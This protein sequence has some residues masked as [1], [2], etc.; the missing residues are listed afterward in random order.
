MHVH[1]QHMIQCSVKNILSSAS[2]VGHNCVHLILNHH[3]HQP[4]L[5]F[6]GDL[7]ITKKL[8]QNVTVGWVLAVQY[9]TILYSAV[10]RTGILHPTKL[11]SPASTGHGH[12][13]DMCRLHTK[14]RYV[15]A[16]LARKS[17]PA[18]RQSTRIWV[19]LVEGNDCWLP[20]TT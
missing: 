8:S 2:R 17:M 10:L 9:R 15:A 5:S 20:K 19:S 11:L 13:C 12:W 7:K 18:C 1:V 3:H 4:Y 6:I 14:P 16:T